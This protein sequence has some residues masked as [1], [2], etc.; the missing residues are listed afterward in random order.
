MRNYNDI[1]R[2]K[3]QVARFAN[4]LAFTPDYPE[5]RKDGFI[6]KYVN[7]ILL[8]VELIAEGRCDQHRAIFP[9][10]KQILCGMA[11]IDQAIRFRMPPRLSDYNL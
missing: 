8:F 4:Q 2:E 6:F 5:P 9:N 1:D 10:G 3:A 7:G 11:E